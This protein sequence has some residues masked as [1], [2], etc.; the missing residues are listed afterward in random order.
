M[1]DATHIPVMN[2]TDI[3]IIGMAAHLPGAP[4]IA[5]YWANLRDGVESIRRLTPAELQATG[6]PAHLINHPNYVASAA[7]LDGFE[8]FDANLAKN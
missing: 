5:A 8:T 6:E 3:A 1:T 2:D 4:S 7:P